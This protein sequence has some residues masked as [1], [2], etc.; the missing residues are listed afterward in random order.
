MKAREP[1]EEGEAK[2]GLG[3]IFA[4]EN[5]RTGR[6]F[7]LA[8]LFCVRYPRYRDYSARLEFHANPL[9]LPPDGLHQY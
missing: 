5:A 8:A 6:G 9:P 1:G 2:N 7:L 4:R 3:K